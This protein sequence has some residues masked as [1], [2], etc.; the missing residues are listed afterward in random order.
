[1]VMK[2]ISRRETE[3]PTRRFTKVQAREQ[4]AT[5]RW[6][7]EIGI[8]V[9]CDGDPPHEPELLTLE[10][11]DTELA[12][13]YVLP[14]GEIA[15]V[16]FAELMVLRFGGLITGSEM[17]M[18]WGDVLDLSDPKECSYYDDLIY[19]WYEFPPKFLNH[20]L[21][22]HVPLRPRREEGAIFATGRGSVPPEYHDHQP[23]AVKLFLMDRA[24]NELS[25]D[26]RARV[27]LMFGARLDRIAKQK[28]E[29][30]PP[31]LREGTR[32][33]KRVPIFKRGDGQAGDQKSVPP[34]EMIK[35]VDANDDINAD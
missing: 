29:R 33:T 17:R 35:Q 6:L 27:D 1:M 8:K 22:H 15:V 25:F 9:E 30:R 2:V 14:W 32:S 20:W 31:E 3:I 4:R 21:T 5:L 26:V 10:Q 24:R 16:W 19:G 18:P 34:G 13:L 7:Q 12:K 28:C 23:V 11:V